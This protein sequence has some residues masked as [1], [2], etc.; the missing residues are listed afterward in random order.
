MVNAMPLIQKLTQRALIITIP[1]LQ[2]K[3]CHHLLWSIACDYECMLGFKLIYIG[4]I[5]PSCSWI[6]VINL[7]ISV[8]VA[9]SHEHQT[10]IRIS[11]PSSWIKQEVSTILVSAM[12]AYA[13]DHCL[14]RSSA[15]TTLIWIHASM[16]RWN[17]GFNQMCHYSVGKCYKM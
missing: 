1:T 12:A 16:S 3:G 11:K 2:V 13:L 7:P 6:T 5:C 14:A 4:K 9:R 8:K 15:I 10:F 17:D